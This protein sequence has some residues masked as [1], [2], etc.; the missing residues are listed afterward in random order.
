M[1]VRQAPGE[2]DAGGGEAGLDRDQAG[3]I[4]GERTHQWV[5]FN[6]TGI[7]APDRRIDVSGLQ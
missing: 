3:R 6:G 7:H 4:P 1:A 2:Q 5:R